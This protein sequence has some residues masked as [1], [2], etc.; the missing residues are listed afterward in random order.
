MSFSDPVYGVSYRMPPGPR[1]GK[2]KSICVFRMRQSYPGSK[3]EQME[4][5]WREQSDHERHKDGAIVWMWET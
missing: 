4:T 5:F 2:K 3:L 1:G